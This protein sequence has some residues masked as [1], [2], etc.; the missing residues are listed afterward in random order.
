[1]NVNGNWNSFLLIVCLPSALLA[2]LA[3]SV[4]FIFF[5]TKAIRRRQLKK[6]AVQD[7]QE[8]RGTAHHHLLHE[9]LERARKQLDETNASL[10]AARKKRAELVDDQNA[11]LQSKLATLIVENNLQEVYGVGEKLK[12]EITRSVFRG[13]LSD[14]HRTD[15]RVRGIGDQKQRAISQWVRQYEAQMPSLMK[16]GFSGQE[17]IVMKYHQQIAA[18]DKMIEAQET[19]QAVLGERIRHLTEELGKLDIISERDFVRALTDPE[20]GSDRLDA[21]LHGVFAEWESMP[22]WFR[23]AIAAEVD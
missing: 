4:Y 20:G 17:A 23:E 15:W 8:A 3:I 22:E 12:G 1:M 13:R 2:L 14:L 6:Q 9:A 16:A 18:Q 11:T 19:R 7:Y 5:R 10:E 21:Y